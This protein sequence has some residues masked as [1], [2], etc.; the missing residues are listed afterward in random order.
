[1]FTDERIDQLLSELENP[2]LVYYDYQPG[3]SVDEALSHPEGDFQFWTNRT[4]QP[5]IGLYRFMLDANMESLYEPAAE[6]VANACRHGNKDSLKPAP[7]GDPMKSLSIKVF[8][9]KNG[10]LFRVRNEGLGFDYQNML[11]QFKSGSHSKN[12][13]GGNGI[14]ILAHPQLVVSYEDEGRITNLLYLL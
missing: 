10:V 1:M 2:K 12:S 13:L 8:T 4:N 3:A 6:M 14:R 5:L 7:N 11:Q 9:G